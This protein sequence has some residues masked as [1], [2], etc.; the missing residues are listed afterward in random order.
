LLVSNHATLPMLIIIVLQELTEL[1]KG[2]VARTA[3]V[4]IFGSA[5]AIG[6]FMAIAIGEKRRARQI[7]S[8]GRLRR[9]ILVN[10][11]TSVILAK[12]ATAIP[13]FH[14]LHSVGTGTKPRVTTNGTG[15]GARTMDLGVHVQLVLVGKL[16][17][18]LAAFKSSIVALNAVAATGNTVALTPLIVAKVAALTPVAAPGTV[19]NHLGVVTVIE[20]KT[21]QY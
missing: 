21:T 13:T 17:V 2:L 14:M 19:A 3:L 15:H 7:G 4:G 20:G 12:T 18:A 1:P 16:T 5:A 6:L 8:H 11:F 10:A 9:G